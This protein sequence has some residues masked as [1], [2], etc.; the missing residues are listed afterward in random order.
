MYRSWRDPL[1]TVGARTAYCVIKNLPE[2]CN[3]YWR[4]DDNQTFQQCNCKDAGIMW[5]RLFFRNTNHERKGFMEN[6]E[7]LST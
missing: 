6:S 7:G 2:E 5:I 3:S 1:V 4:V